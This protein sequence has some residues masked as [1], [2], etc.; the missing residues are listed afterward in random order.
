MTLEGTTTGTPIY[1]SP[2][3]ASG[4]H[5]AAPC[6]IYSLGVIAYE[7]PSGEPPFD[8]SSVTEVT[9]KHLSSLPEPL[10]DRRSAPGG[11]LPARASD[12]R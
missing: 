1:M 12:A 6:D 8:G 11:A 9:R 3:Q 4:H 5:I 2:E 10:S 7:V